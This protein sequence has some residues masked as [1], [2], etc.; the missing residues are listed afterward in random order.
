MTALGKLPGAVVDDGHPDRRV[1]AANVVAFPYD[2][3]KSITEAAECLAADVAA[4][5]SALGAG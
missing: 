5:L 2:F 3:R 1:P 4:R